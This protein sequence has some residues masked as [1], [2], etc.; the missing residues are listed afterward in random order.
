MKLLA[1]DLDRTLLPNGSQK[2]DASV[3]AQLRSLFLQKKITIIYVTGRRKE[4][5]QSV[6]QKYNLPRPLYC[7]TNVGTQIYR[8]ERGRYILD[9]GWQT[10][11]RRK[12]KEGSAQSI[13]KALTKSTL[14]KPQS[15]VTQNE[16][17]R[18]FLASPT[19]SKT[20][21]ITEIRKTLQGIITHYDIT[22]SIDVARNIAQIDIMPKNVN[23]KEAL[24]YLL[25]SMKRVDVVVSGDSGNDLSMLQS[26]WKSI[27]VKNASD[28]V[29]KAYQSKSFSSKKRY[30]ATGLFGINGNYASGIVEG[31]IQYRWLRD[32]DI[33]IKRSVK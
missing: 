24:R 5:I 10:V 2:K 27:L 7:I 33:Q 15:K 22:Y 17:K 19:V 18:S 29:K 28:S 16:F 30:I 31:L 9:E 14:L 25:Q 13:S 32:S 11:L 12:W 26:V 3:Y 1:T 4:Q 23:K 20:T 6:I 21:I 8:Y